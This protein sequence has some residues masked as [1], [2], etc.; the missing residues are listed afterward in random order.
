M[1]GSL[2]S[3]RT[4]LRFGERAAARRGGH[5]WWF[6]VTVVMTAIAVFGVACSGSGGEDSTEGTVVGPADARA[7]VWVALGMKRDQS[8]LR[9]A[10]VAAA[11]PEQHE[12]LHFMS[13]EE[14]RSAHGAGSDTQ[15]ATVKALEDAG[16]K[17]AADPTGGVVVAEMTVKDAE[18]LFGVD[19]VVERASDGS[20][21]IE[22]KGSLDVPGKLKDVGVT[23]V[24]GLRA[25]TGADAQSSSTTIDAEEQSDC[26]GADDMDAAKVRA[27]R[28]FY[29]Y[30][31]AVSD[32]N[33][34][35]DVSVGMFATGAIAE[36]T[37]D[38]WAHCYSITSVPTLHAV[39][40]NLTT[41]LTATV[42]PVIDTVAVSAVARGLPA[43][44][45]FQF[46]PV[47]S[48]VFPLVSTLEQG[49]ADSSKLVEILFTTEVVCE[50]ALS[51]DEL[52]MTEWLLAA[53]A[54]AGVSVLASAGD[55]GSSGCYPPDKS[56]KVQYPS[57]SSFATGVGGTQL[58]YASG[59]VIRQSVWEQPDA[60][61]PAAGGGG[62]S[63]R[64]DRPTFQQSTGMNSSRRQV[65]D[66]SFLAAPEEVPTVPF[67]DGTSCDWESLGGTSAS[68][69]GF[70][71]VLAAV[72]G[73]LAH[74]GGPDRLGN[75]NA[76]I[77]SIATGENGRESVMDVT[78]GD[79][80]LYSVGC[81]SAEKGYD[82]ASGWGSLRVDEFL[83]AVKRLRDDF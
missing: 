39:S 76:L 62:P 26:V 40:A 60:D 6:A 64:F 46:D 1:A 44:E 49:R 71:G 11:D 70:A 83:D 63:D 29:G 13:L 75:V 51:D 47:T 53:A 52:S 54:L 8:G 80:D 45:M 36:S 43:I 72:L 59:R 50:V 20:E 10:A 41:P 24:V 17:A 30:T 56:E 14:I 9:S 73:N 21:T 22:P 38:L 74:D 35:S 4:M 25:T 33:V 81:C 12:Y 67:C 65:P 37:L 7:K 77:V 48:L 68:T 82:M 69:P 27:T 79:N 3:L 57:S 19:L 55:D 28:E 31:P 32:P 42:E 58:T 15:E 66:L 23:E 61:P 18:A 78:S 2:G 5:Q 16:A 34:F